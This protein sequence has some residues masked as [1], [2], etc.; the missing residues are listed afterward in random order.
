MVVQKARKQG[1]VNSKG[2][3][4]SPIFSGPFVAYTIVRVLNIGL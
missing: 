3:C 4:H 1:S 2:K